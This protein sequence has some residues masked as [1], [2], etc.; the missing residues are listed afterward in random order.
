MAMQQWHLIIGLVSD[1]AYFFLSEK[2]QKNRME[3]SPEWTQKCFPDFSPESNIGK[4]A[5]DRV[6]AVR[7]RV[8]WAKKNGSP[9]GSCRQG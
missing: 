6:I 8:F 1:K 9:P 7:L 5:A 3:S 2:N 4:P